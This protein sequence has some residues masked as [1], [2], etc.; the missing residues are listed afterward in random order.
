MKRVIFISVLLMG[1]F[2]YNSAGA[3]LNVHLNA[4]IG[5]QPA[6]GPVGYD[7]ADYY[8]LPDIEAYYSVSRH[9]YIYMNNGNWAFSASLPA[10]YRNYDLYHAHKVVINEPRPYLHHEVYRARYAQFRGR[11]DQAVIR[12]SHEQK[13]ME[14]KY[15]P[16]H[17][18]WRGAHDNQRGMHDDH[19]GHYFIQTKTLSSDKVFV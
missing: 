15:H 1:S 7:H 12:D 5:I 19:N 16:E 8:Y 11:H 6:W 3:Q 4:N 14:S 9:Q 10:R 2:L 17:N 18:K 13:Y